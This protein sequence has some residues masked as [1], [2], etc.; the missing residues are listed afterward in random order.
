VF[1]EA[2]T[3]QGW[4]VERLASL[5][6]S[7]VPG[8]GLPRESTDAVCE[9]W[10]TDAL[11]RLNP[12]IAKKPERVDEVLPVIRAAILSAASDGLLAANER[13]TTILRGEHPF[14]FVGEDHYVTVRLIDFDDLAN[15]EFVVSGPL[16]GSQNPIADEV[17]YG[18]AVAKQRRFDVV[19]WVNGLPLVVVETKTPV[20]AAVSWLNGARDIANTYEKDCPAFFATNVV[21]GAT[22]GREF[23]YGA[24]GQPGESWLMW[25]ST[26]D[27]YNLDGLPRVERSVDLLLTP[28]RILSIL[29][30]FTL[31]ERL[32]GGWVRK[33]IPRYPQ[34]EAAELIHQ[35]VLA[36]G[37]KGLI[38]HYQGTGKSLLMAFA[39]LML[40][41]DETVG[42]PTVLVV[43]D[44]LDLVEQVQR[45]F[46]T[47]GL[48][49]L[50]VAESKGELRRLLAEDRRGIIVTTIFRF[51]GAGELNTRD[52]VIVFVD[53]AHRTTEGTLGEDMREALPNARFF[54]LT[55]TPI[56]DKERNTFR[57]FGDPKDPGHVMN[58]YSMERSISDG[59]SVPVH[60][61]TRLVDFQLDRAALDEAEAALADE[62]N[63][64]DEEREFLAQKAGHVKTILL[65][66][67]RIR[68]V[69]A[70]I[71]DHY[72]AK[73]A[74]N[75]FKAQVVAFDRELVVAYMQELGRLIA[76]R[77]LPYETAVVM[78]V[79]GKDEP[80]SWLEYALDRA[81]EAHIKARFNAPDDPLTFVIVT[82]K[83]LTGFDAP[84][85]Q[86]MYLDR[87]LRRHTLFQAI[88]R[89]NRRY[90]NPVTRAEKNYG[91]IVDYIGLGNQIALALKAAD[92]DQPGKRPVDVNALAAEFEAQLAVALQRFAGID[93]TDGSFAALQAALQRLPDQEARDAFAKEFTACE[94]LWEF[95][96]PH[97]TLDTRRDDYRWLAQ[98]YTASRPSKPSND[99]LWARLGAKTM[100]MV[101]GAMSDVQVTGTGLEEVVVDPEAIEAMRK[102][103]GQ[104]AID[105]PD[106]RDLAK[107]PVTLDEVLTAIDRRIQQRL[108][109]SGHHIYR[110]LAEQIEN[111]RQMALS[112]AE[113]SV[114]FLKRALE[115]ARAA[116]QAEKLEATGELDAATESLLD[117]HIGALTQIV[118]QYAP[119]GAPIVI[120]DVV[121]DI[122]AIVKQVRFTGWAENQDG[123]KAVRRELRAVLHKY[124]LP[125]TGQ[126]FNSA[127]AYIRENY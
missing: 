61:E 126:P 33:L 28:E 8:Q 72:T 82:A 76:E 53:E 124:G 116:L 55:G 109:A 69:C 118:Q 52:N 11:L 65:N 102:L 67:D 108:N 29:R 110:T 45:Q 24:V 115:I 60:V 41:N 5:G 19:L 12:V 103:V 98:V 89:T 104:G 84:I 79:G 42:G 85:E 27:P 15:N 37:S 107:D 92:P 14:K 58:T 111:L 78:T 7:H 88:T 32:P 66:P 3:V 25:G 59:A 34:V 36:G 125:V 94:A 4:L 119:A 16:P 62:E 113:D 10:L 54:G 23:H 77:G 22:E 122:D 43:L 73:I 123:D 31:F 86:V 2:A 6:W 35:R 9:P 87:P 21:V 38:W 100:A 117:P 70:D 80:T 112:R 81:T 71:L 106:D 75:G 99:L 91:L 95:L 13:L 83:L 68:A 105:L 121:R 114:E 46:Q 101:H 64:T 49:R 51:E 63:L 56:A 90:T 93:R 18:P 44:R 30:D 96:D 74:P 47:A 48:P 57:L 50:T 40:L 1:S 120:A 127:Y 20:N 39:A 26:Q 97:P 17:T